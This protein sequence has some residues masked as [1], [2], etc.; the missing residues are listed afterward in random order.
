MNDTYKADNIISSLTILQHD[1]EGYVK[2]MWPQKLHD[3]IKVKEDALKLLKN[4]YL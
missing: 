4:V 2:L 3:Y 1:L